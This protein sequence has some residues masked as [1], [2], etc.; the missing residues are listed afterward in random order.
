[1][2][3]SREAKEDKAYFLSQI[4]KFREAQKKEEEDGGQAPVF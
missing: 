4:E 2:R 3:A 1:L